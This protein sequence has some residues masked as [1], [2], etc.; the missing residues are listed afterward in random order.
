MSK[1]TGVLQAESGRLPHVGGLHTCA[2][3]YSGLLSPP[4]VGLLALAVIGGV[5]R[6][7]SP[8]GLA[9]ATV[10][11]TGCGAPPAAYAFLAGS[12]DRSLTRPR[13][14]LQRLEQRER[15]TTAL[16][17]LTALALGIMLVVGCHG[18][19]P[20]AM[21][22]VFSAGGIA[23]AAALTRKRKISV[24]T[25]TLGSV[26]GLLGAEHGSWAIPGITLA[27]VMGWARV[28]VGA[29]TPTEAAYGLLFGLAWV[30]LF[31]C[32]PDWRG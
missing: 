13:P 28:R 7:P 21:F 6:W 27:A 15:I 12:R 29:H 31:V 16:V 10:L 18:P 5:S 1:T 9:W 3:V 8:S 11:A 22:L 23:V 2:L 19:R 20:L 30:S 25:G 32:L 14:T 24:H 17:A 26:L 4:V